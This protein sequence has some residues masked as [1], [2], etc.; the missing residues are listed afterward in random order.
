MGLALQPVFDGIVGRATDERIERLVRLIA[1]KI[2]AQVKGALTNLSSVQE[3]SRWGFLHEEALYDDI[4]TVTENK[5]VAEIQ[6]V[7]DDTKLDKDLDR[8]QWWLLDVDEDEIIAILSA[9]YIVALRSAAEQ[10]VN[11]MY[12]AGVLESPTIDPN[13]VFRLV[14]EATIEE[15]AQTAALM[16]ANVNE[17]T[18]YYLRRMIVSGIRRGLT[19]QEIIAKIRAGVDINEILD[20]NLFMR[21]VAD[22]VKSQIRDL[23]EYRIRSIVSFEIRS[24]ETQAWLKQFKSMGLT[25]KRWKHFGS[26]IPCPVC[27]ENIDVGDVPLDYK[28][29]S[30]FGSVDVPLAHPHCHCGIT[31]NKAELETLI[32]DG[33]FIIWTGD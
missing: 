20:D 10:M 27:Q 1:P 24:A 9:A 4:T 6:K 18:K 5:E 22:S 15:L 23:T 7:A 33:K 32:R 12:L 2:F 21:K 13:V 14:N 26:D 11:D 19:E 31:Y 8:D 3:L 29:E 25:Q 16:V 30:V 28:F 17:G